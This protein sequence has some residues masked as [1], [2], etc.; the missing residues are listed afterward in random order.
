MASERMRRI[1]AGVLSGKKVNE[2]S[3]LCCF[4]FY[5]NGTVPNTFWRRSVWRS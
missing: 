4:K 3:S 5:G 2:S 1:L